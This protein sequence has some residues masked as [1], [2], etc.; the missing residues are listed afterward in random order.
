MLGNN[1]R[2]TFMDSQQWVDTVNNVLGSQ[3]RLLISSDVYH[4]AFHIGCHWLALAGIGLVHTSWHWFPF[5]QVKV[6]VMLLH[7]WSMY[8]DGLHVHS[9]C[10]GWIIVHIES[11][12]HIFSA[13]ATTFWLA[14]T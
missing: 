6:G 9:S 13:V 4:A 2:L 7:C 1:G 12:N 14:R 3:A 5:V 11:P 8:T 10:H